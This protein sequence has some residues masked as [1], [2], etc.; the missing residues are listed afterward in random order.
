MIMKTELKIKDKHLFKIIVFSLLICLSSCQEF[1]ELDPPNYLLTGE[2]VFTDKNTVKAAILGIYAQ[3]RSNVLLTG[4]SQG[5]SNLMGM[6]TDELEFFGNTSLPDDAFFKNNLLPSNSNV[7]EIWNGSYNLIYAAN[8]IIEGVEGSAYFTAEEAAQFS[9]EAKFLRA[10]VHFYLYNLYGD[11]P[12]ITTTNYIENQSVTRD[13]RETVFDNIIADLIN[14]KENLPETEISGEHIRADARTARAFLARVYL[15]NEQWQNAEEM[16]SA[17]I[18]QSNWEPNLENV[19]LKESPS[20]IFQLMPQF[21]GMNTLEAQTFIFTTAPPPTR[22]LSQQLINSFETNDLRKS[23][24]IEGVSDGVQTFY[25]PFKYKHRAGEGSNSEYSVILRLAE[26]YLIRA[27]ARVKLGYISGAKEDLNK[28]RARAG[29]VAITSANTAELLQTILHE[30]QVELFTEH[31]HRFF[32][33]KRTGSLST[34]LESVKPGW[35]ST[36]QLLPIPEKEILTN[37]NL[38]PQN[39]GY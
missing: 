1:V 25:Y 18:S 11:I 34:F 28:I 31:G 10:L 9:G 5:M 30:R 21:D 6:Y 38:Q 20:I 4:T 29:L 7:A 36:D 37:P 23:I 8:A 33:L 14:A 24:W 17:V 32:D 35:N 12:Y 22:A 39:P 19:F 27:E 2:N 3:L 13:Q 15:F 26:Q 16:A